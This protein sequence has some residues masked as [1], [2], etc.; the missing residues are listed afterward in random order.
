MVVLKFRVEGW[1]VSCDA[2]SGAKDSLELSYH[3]LEADAGAFHAGGGGKVQKGGICGDVA[4][5]ELDFHVGGVEGTLD[6]VDV[7]H[8]SKGDPG[9]WRCL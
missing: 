3:H 2:G 6:H 5:T 9:A 4:K 7:S 8:I 1:V